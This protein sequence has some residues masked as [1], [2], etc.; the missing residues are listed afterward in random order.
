MTYAHPG[1]PAHHFRLD[2]AAWAEI[3]KAYCAGATATALGL[4]W[5]VSPSTIYRQAKLRGWSKRVHASDLVRA[6]H[7]PEPQGR[8]DYGPPGEVFAPDPRH[9]LD[10][11]TACELF[12]PGF[13][14]QVAGS[15]SGGAML[16]G[17]IADSFVLA[18]VALAQA[19]LAKMRPQ[20]VREII[21]HALQDPEETDA[22]FSA[23][24]RDGEAELKDAYW[25][26]RGEQMR[27]EVAALEAE[28]AALTAALPP[29]AEPC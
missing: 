23:K 13:L 3:G 15:A 10:R 8:V 22:L 9:F 28:V 24:R 21:F 27:R 7:P 17:Q 25:R 14:A 16:T 26:W 19:K 12:D 6:S 4:K 5:K 20:S 11:Y 18:R 1:A 29:T 2:A